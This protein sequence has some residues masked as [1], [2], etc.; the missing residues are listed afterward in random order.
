MG[1]LLKVLTAIVLATTVSA[2]TAAAQQPR[3][4]ENVLSDYSPNPMNPELQGKS[5]DYYINSRCAGLMVALPIAAGEDVDNTGRLAAI[6][7]TEMS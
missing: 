7:F 1:R 4:I 2:A 5:R 3:T 6:I